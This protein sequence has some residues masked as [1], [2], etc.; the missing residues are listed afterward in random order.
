MDGEK[1]KV[2]RIYNK[3]IAP[4]ALVV[5]MVVSVCAGSVVTLPK[6]AAQTAP[7]DTMQFRYNAAHTGD[8]SPV[9]GSVTSNGQLKWSLDVGY[10]IW[11]SVVVANDMAFLGTSDQKIHAVS[12]T[13]QKEAWSTGYSA[14]ALAVADNLLFA[15]GGSNLYVL[16]ASDGTLLWSHS[17]G[18]YATSAPTVANGVVYISCGG[19]RH[20]YAFNTGDG[21]LK[22]SY[23]AGGIAPTVDNGVVYYKADKTDDGT[24]YYP[25]LL[26][27][28]AAT[29]KEIWRSNRVDGSQTVPVVYNGVIYTTRPMTA[30]YRYGIYALNANDGTLKWEYTIGDGVLNSPAVANGVVYFGSQDH[31]LYAVD[32]NTGTKLWSYTTGSQIGY[33][34]PAY[35]NGV[36]YINP[37]VPDAT[38]YAVDANTGSKLWSYALEEGWKDPV[39]ANGVVYIAAGSTLY[40]I[41]SQSTPPS[42]QPPTAN[43]GDDQSVNLGAAV[44]LDGTKSA[45]PENQPLTY[46]WSVTSAPTGSTAALS[47]T[48][49]VKPTFTPDKPGVYEIQLIVTDSLNAASQPDKVKITVNDLPTADAGPTQSIHVG[50][51]V[52]LDGSQSKDSDG[53]VQKYAWTLVSAPAGSNPTLSDPTAAKSTFTPDKLGSYVFALKVTDDKGAQSSNTA[54]VTITATNDPPIAKAGP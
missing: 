19:D 32:A 21:S 41:G 48:D 37:A 20:L 34:S 22:W 49:S 15:S 3:K 39:V 42:N 43:A 2:I 1:L 16:H 6:V 18:G 25:I 40:A 36:V 52:T 5:V 45:D 29:G 28:D 47:T 35:A 12:V 17:F 53:T 4:L 14:S 46:A 27:L 33:S 38:L 10:E 30:G 13:T 51:L 31:N 23:D 9:A 7:T 50:T 11:S 44:T 26:A 24:N 54:Q 8:F